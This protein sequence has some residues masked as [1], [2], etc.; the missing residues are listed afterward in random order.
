M[1]EKELLAA[2]R[3]SGGN[4]TVSE[5]KALAYY[6]IGM[7]RLRKGDK[8][9]AREWFQKCKN[10]GMK[11]FVEYQFAVAELSRLDVAAP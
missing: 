5:Q 8:T 4:S 3:K 6:Y 2:A 9:G 11:E 10:A 7:M 1:D